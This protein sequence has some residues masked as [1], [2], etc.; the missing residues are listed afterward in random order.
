MSAVRWA[1]ALL[2]TE[3]LKSSSKGPWPSLAH[4]SCSYWLSRLPTVTVLG[5]VR[6]LELGDHYST[7][8]SSPLT[9]SVILTNSSSWTKQPHLGSAKPRA[10]KASSSRTT[11]PTGT[12]FFLSFQRTR[13]S[14]LRQVSR[15][16]AAHSP[17][18]RHQTNP[19]KDTSSHGFKILSTSLAEG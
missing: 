16:L 11:D 6:C 14:K 15:V 3:V 5:L 18:S 10:Q 13:V 17:V 19:E 4:S 1:T 7:P 8:P 9:L 12:S 2:T